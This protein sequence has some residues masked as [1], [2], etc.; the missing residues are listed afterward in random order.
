[1]QK[2]QATLSI[3]TDILHLRCRPSE[4]YLGAVTSRGKLMF[5]L[6]WDSNIY[7]DDL[8]RE[9]AEEVRAAAVHYLGQSSQATSMA[10]RTPVSTKTKL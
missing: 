10:T 9:W 1:M 7:S 5:F 4:L 6:Y 3:V 2:Q 8:V